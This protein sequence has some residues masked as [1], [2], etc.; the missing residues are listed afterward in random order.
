MALQYIAIWGFVAL[1]SSALAGI[2][3]SVKNREYSFWMAWCFLLPPMV[4]VL[5]VMPSRSGPRPQ[6]PAMD[7]DD[8]HEN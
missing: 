4:L 6:R 1:V 5:A 8:R 7:A 3:A 2:I